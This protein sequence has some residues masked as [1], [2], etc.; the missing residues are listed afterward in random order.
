MF[1]SKKPD[2]FPNQPERPHG[3]TCPWDKPSCKGCMLWVGLTVE[4]DKGEPRVE[5]RCAP[6]WAAVNGTALAVRLDG[7][8]KAVEGMR[9]QFATFKQSL[10]GLLAGLVQAMPPPDTRQLTRLPRTQ[11]VYAEVEDV[12]AQE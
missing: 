5:Y 10:A 8:Q 1:N 12:R 9:N 4:N 7:V 11:Q 3:S 6:A 2:P